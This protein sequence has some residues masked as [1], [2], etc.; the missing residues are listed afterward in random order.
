MY[1]DLPRSHRGD[2][3]LNPVT[4]E[5]SV[6]LI[7][8]GDER[9]DRL[10]VQLQVSP[11]GAVAGEHYHPS[12]TERFRVLR[13]ELQVSLDGER[14]TLERGADVTVPPGTTHDWWN[15]SAEDVEVLVDVSPG[16]R[17]ELM[18]TTLWGLAR[19]GKTN[20][21]GM[22]GALQLAVIGHEFTDVIRFTRPPAV[23]QKALFGPLAA[24][25]RARGYRPVYPEYLQP[26]G[27]EEPRRE[28]LALVE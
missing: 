28:I 23:V 14:R 26:Q 9:G 2:V 16:R 22:P 1:E 11:G 5:R 4:G 15:A 13:G 12:I 24:L 21:K 25:G 6:V 10:A 7:G 19:D 20:S 8:T 18:I 27:R 3:V 17:F